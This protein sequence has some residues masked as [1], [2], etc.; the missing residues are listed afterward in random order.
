M[1][2]IPKDGNKVEDGNEKSNI[3][4]PESPWNVNLGNSEEITINS[5]AS[6]RV[7]AYQFWWA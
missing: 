7:E 4:C 2:I 1:M 3:V 5:A 6:F